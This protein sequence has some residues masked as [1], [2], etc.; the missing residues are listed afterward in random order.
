MKRLRPRFSL[1]FMTLAVTVATCLLQGTGVLQT[2]EWMIL[3]QWLRSR[4][5][6]ARSV[7]IVLVTITESDIQ[8]LGRWPLSDAQLADLL[9]RLKRDRPIA[10]GLDIYRDLP[11]QP[12]HSQL[13][14]LFKT[15][16]NL[17]GITKA[18]GNSTGPA[19]QAPPILRDRG[20]IGVNDVIVDSDGKI[21]RNLLSIGESG[22]ETPALGVKL[23]LNY[24]SHQGVTAQADPQNDCTVLGKAKFCRLDGDAAGYVRSDMGGFQTLSNFLRTPEGIPSY[25]YSQVMQDRLPPQLLQNKIV[26]IGVKAESVWSDRFYTPY[27]SDSKTTWAGVELHANVAAQMISSALEGRPS[28]QALPLGEAGLWILLW[29]IGGTGLGWICHNRRWG[30]IMLPFCLS[31]LMGLA[32]GAFLM[33]WWIVVV[34]PAIAFLATGLLSHRHWVWQTLQQTNALLELKV[35]ERTQELLEKNIALEQARLSA[36][37]ANRSLEQLVRTDAL[38]QVANR[39]YFNEYLEQEWQRMMRAQMPLSLILI[40][41]DFFKYYNDTYGHPAGDDCLVKVAAV[42]RSEVKRPTDLVARYGGEEFAVILPNTP[43]AGAVQIANAMRVKL[44]EVKIPHQRSQVSAHVTMSMGL[45]CGIPISQISLNQLLNATDKA[46]YKA[47]KAGRDR[48]IAEAFN[49]H[50]GLGN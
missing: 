46:L 10:I 24:L 9:N 4:P 30:L 28:L 39:R 26:L 38:T 12:G 42:L 47:K 18:V 41:I 17:I 44:H 6:E 8:S 22:A 11:I 1:A 19:V 50:D 7:P 15:T 3:D 13:L 45:V 20:Q 32:Y 36:E 37:A 14:Q 43:I 25:S 34:S 49:T 23:A 2:L 35:Q 40:D 31:S 21:R 16:P 48:V 27:T 33:G 5:P 29:A